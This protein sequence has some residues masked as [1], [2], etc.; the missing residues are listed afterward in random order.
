MRL[1]LAAIARLIALLAVACGAVVFFLPAPADVPPAA[2]KAL[3]VVIAAIGLWS[4][5]VV[6]VYLT[7]IIFFLV[8]VV[9]GVA[10]VEVVFSGFHSSAVWLVFGG[11]I[12]G[13]AVQRTGLG[14]RAARLFTGRPQGSYFKVVAGCVAL[15]LGL[16]FLVPAAVGRI[17]ILL[18]IMLAVADRLGFAPG[19]PGRTGIALAVGAGTLIPAFTIL[20]SN[21]PN[22][23]L[24]GAA[25]SIYGIQFAYSEF[26]LVNFTVMGVLVAAALPVLIAFLF[27]D[28]PAPKAMEV[29]FAA[30]PWSAPERRLLVYLLAALALWITDFAHGISPAWI[31]LA[32]G[33]LCLLPRHGVVPPQSMIEDVNYAPWFFVAGI[34]GMGSVVTHTG[35]GA[36]IGRELFAVVE[37]TPGKDLHNFAAVFGIGAGVGALTTLPGAPGVMTPLASAIADATGWPITTVLMAQVPTWVVFAFPYQAPP[38]ILTIML[39]DVRMADA[40]KLLLALALFGV[41][42]ILPLQYVWWR[43]L[44]LI[45]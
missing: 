45:G 42:V 17:I 31:A 25:E 22:V 8:A 11:L 23:A 43:V 9:A 6:P 5:A 21:V 19:R 29:E 3:G 20:P 4:T 35:L 15:S 30:K 34:I 13:A 28:T 7:S 32:A 12:I 16:A 26:L 44:G 24:A 38:I 37:L 36:M 1:H 33:L 27:A 2:L 40:L 39:A 41:T 18:P 14:A 10:P